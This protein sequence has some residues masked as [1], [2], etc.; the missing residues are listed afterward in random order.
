MGAFEYV[1]VDATGRERKGVLEG[2]TPRH[3]RSLLRE[4]ELL[5]LE[6]NEVSQ[7]GDIRR[8]RKPLRRG[9]SA[10]D[11]T[12]FTRQLATLVRS[13]LPLEEALSAVGEQTE[14][15]R[16]KSV[17]VGVRAKVMEGHALADGLG[18]FPQAFPELYRATVSAGEQSGHLDGVLERLADYTESRQRLR[19]QVASAL[20]YPCV[21]ILMALGIIALMMTYVVPKVVSVFETSGQSLPVL[22]RGLIGLSDFSRDYGLFVVIALVVGFFGFRRALRN[23][24]VRMRWDRFKLRLPILGRLTRALNTSRFTRTLAILAGSGVAVL[25]ALRI[26]GQVVENL[27]M[28]RAIEDAAARV[29]EGAGIARSLAASRLFPP[30]MVHLIAS[31][32]TSGRLEEMLGRTADNQENEINTILTTVLGL[33]APLVIVLM[34]G[35]V[36]I[37]VLAIL[38]PIINMNQLVM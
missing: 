30:M 27:P 20:A 7:R 38:L 29:R 23:E 26:A 2:D 19:Q 12:L 4:R 34:G 37:I 31:G 33:L 14:K 17:I 22:T 13:G 18:D 8:G 1:A 35:M 6:V 36:L 11:L 3:V 21:L 15:P 16:V 9:I 25:D 5:P 24:S 10:G 28:R 32:E